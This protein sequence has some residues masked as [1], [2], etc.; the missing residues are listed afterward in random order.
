MYWRLVSSYSF[1][2]QRGVWGECLPRKS[3]RSVR[4]CPISDVVTLGTSKTRKKARSWSEKEL[5]KNVRS[6]I[7][8]IFSQTI[9]SSYYNNKNHEFHQRSY[10]R[11]PHRRRHLWID[12]SPAWPYPHLAHV[13]G[14]NS[15]DGGSG[16]ES[17]QPL[18]VSC[19]QS[20]LHPP[21]FL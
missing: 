1:D 5:D 15:P 10:L 9:Q 14:R 21:G 3:S 11:F 20:P 4:Y 19:T 17:M 16:R 6:S 18:S 2:R 12:L 8:S 7:F 13:R